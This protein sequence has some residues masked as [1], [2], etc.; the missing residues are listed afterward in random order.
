MLDHYQLSDL[1][2]PEEKQ[3]Q[4]TAREFLEAE[5]L[6]HIR[7]WWEEGTFPMHIGRKLGELGFLGATLPA[8]YG[9]HYM[10][11]L[12]NKFGIFFRP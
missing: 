7:D 9:E 1:F 11:G 6:P 2:S 10:M 5:A 4:A 8:K 3:V 12:Q